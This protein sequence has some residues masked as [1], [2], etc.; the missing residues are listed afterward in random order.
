LLIG[1]FNFFWTIPVSSVA[2]DEQ[3]PAIVFYNG[4]KKGSF[5]AASIQ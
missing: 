1:L 3:L 2:G 5:A 4:I